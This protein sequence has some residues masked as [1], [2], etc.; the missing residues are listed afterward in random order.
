MSRT[1][2]ILLLGLAVLFP[3]AANAQT[4]I[5][6]G[7]SGN[8]AWVVGQTPGGPGAYININTVRNSAAMTRVSGSGAAATVMT[9]Q[10]ST[11]MWVG[12]APTTWA[13]TLP[14][15][16]QDGAIVTLGTDTTLTSMVT[17]TA[18]A[19]T[20]LNATYNA[21]TL[22]AVTSVIFQ[23]SVGNTTWYRLQ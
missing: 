7:V 21:Q 1:L 4:V 16:P 23:Y 3:G 9:A 20:T 19:G 10:Q 13:V 18:A 17:V 2:R 22:T 6:S 12:T 14:P 15:S 5:Q 11:L 8:E